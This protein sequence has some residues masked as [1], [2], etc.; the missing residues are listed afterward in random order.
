M[1]LVHSS[2]DV[3]NNL[4]CIELRGKSFVP[5]SSRV[6]KYR[7][8]SEGLIFLLGSYSEDNLA[9]LGPMECRPPSCFGELMMV[10]DVTTLSCCTAQNGLWTCRVQYR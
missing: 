9:S 4:N 10:T 7:E 1:F 6:H 2:K 3:T 5:S 8:G